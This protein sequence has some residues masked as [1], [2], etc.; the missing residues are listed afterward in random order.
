VTLRL[1]KCIEVPERALNEFASGHLVEA[2]FQKDFSELS[3][4]LQERV[5]MSALWDLTLSVEVVFL[6]FGLFPCSAPDH[7]NSQVSLEFLSLSGKV[8]ALRDLVALIS[9]YINELS[10][11]HLFNYLLVMCFKIIVLG[12][13]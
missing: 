5:K 8:G 3:A 2:H 13:L 12:I 4:H 9:D 11:L 7:I 6:E 1:E 10:F